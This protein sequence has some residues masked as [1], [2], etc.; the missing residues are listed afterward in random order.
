MMT[1]S[2]AEISLAVLNIWQRIAKLCKLSSVLN[3]EKV[4]GTSGLISPVSG[5]I[6]KK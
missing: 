6:Q 2:E 5:Q 3:M 4:I 1:E